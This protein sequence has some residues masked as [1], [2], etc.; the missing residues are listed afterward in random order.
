[1]RKIKLEE[2]KFEKNEYL[3]KDGFETKHTNKTDDF[4][5][6]ITNNSA[7]YSPKIN[8]IKPKYFYSILKSNIPSDKSLSNY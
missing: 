3:L 7:I 1:M 6:S 2:K 8:G 4:S 5:M